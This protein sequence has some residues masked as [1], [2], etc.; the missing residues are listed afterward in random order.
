[1]L[2]QLQSFGDFNYVCVLMFLC[3]ALSV[4]RLSKE[5]VRS[6]GV[7]NLLHCPLSLRQVATS[8]LLAT[9]LAVISYLKQALSTS[10][11]L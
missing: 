5:M 8:Q 3:V 6:S 11:L 10:C 4:Q 1:M 9:L 7:D 2:V